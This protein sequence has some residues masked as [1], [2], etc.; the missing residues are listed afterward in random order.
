MKTRVIPMLLQNYLKL[1]LSNFCPLST[2]KILETSKLQ[3]IF[4]Q[5]NFW[6]LVELR[7]DNGFSSIHVVKYSIAITVNLQ[8]P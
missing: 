1:S 2:I 8:L 3:M 6:T 5:K 7:F 4:C